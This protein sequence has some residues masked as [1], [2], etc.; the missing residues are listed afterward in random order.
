[1]WLGSASSYKY[2]VNNLF[3]QISTNEFL[4]VEDV[5]NHGYNFATS[6]LIN[7]RTN[8]NSWTPSTNLGDN[9]QWGLDNGW[10]INRERNKTAR[11]TSPS[12]SLDTYRLTISFTHKYNLG[13][14][15]ALVEY[16][17]NGTSWTSLPLHTNSQP[18]ASGW[19]GSS[20]GDV[21][22]VGF[23]DVSP[24]SSSFFLRFSASF[25]DVSLDS[26]VIGWQ[27]YNVSISPYGSVPYSYRIG[28]YPITNAEYCLFL[29]S[30]D[31]QGTNPNNVYDT[32]LGLSS[33]ARGGIDLVTSQNISPIRPYG[34]YY[35][36]RTTSSATLIG[37]M[38]DKPVSYISWLNAARFC[39]WLHNGAR[40]YSRTDSSATAP[41][42]TGA[43]EVGTLTSISAPLQPNPN[44]KFKIP[45]INEWIKAAY[46][47]SDGLSS[48]YWMY[49]TQS[50]IEPSCIPNI[51]VN[52]YPILLPTYLSALFTDVPISELSPEKNVVSL[53]AND[54]I[55]QDNNFM[56]VAS[57]FTLFGLDTVISE[58][59]IWTK[60]NNIL[61]TLACDICIGDRILPVIA[62]FQ[63][64]PSILKVQG[65]S[66][67]ISLIGYVTM[68]QTLSYQWQKKALGDSS[69]SNISGAN[70]NTLNLTGLTIANND[71]DEYRCLLTATGGAND[72]YSN[73]TQLILKTIITITKQPENLTTSDGTVLFSVQASSSP[74][75]ILWYQWEMALPNDPTNFSIISSPQNLNPTLALSGLTYNDNNKIYRC[76][77]VSED[78]L[79]F[80]YSDSATLQIAPATITITSQ[81]PTILKTTSG[82]ASI[83]ISAIT[84]TGPAP[85]RPSAPTN[86][87]AAAG[88]SGSLFVSWITPPSTSTI[89]SYVIEYTPSGG[90]PQTILTNS[91]SNFYYLTGLTNNLQYSIRVR[92]ISFT[93]G[94]W[95]SS[96]SAV[97]NTDW[98]K[99]S[100]LLKFEGS[101]FV[102]SSSYSHSITT[103]G[104]NAALSSTQSKFSGGK[105]VLF[106][107]GNITIP[108][109][110]AFGMGTGDFTIE[111]FAYP[112]STSSWNGIINLGTY[113]DGL[114]FRSGTQ[115]D[116]FYLTNAF[117][118]NWNPNTNMPLNTWTHIAIVRNGSDLRVYTNGNIALSITSTQNLGSSKTVMIGASAHA[119]NEAFLGY[120]DEVRIIK[121]TGIYTGT[122]FVPPSSP[123]LVGYI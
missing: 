70:S 12:I 93:F 35:R 107:G 9:F 69:F 42:N 5:N 100:L 112:T 21:I 56:P 121:G 110:T 16:S 11:I 28:K 52:G 116:N 50:D 29:N 43:Y 23:L 95:S 83:S 8:N 78:G 90:T 104:S 65:S 106:S 13:S 122:S 57:V 49:P 86:V 10:T 85:G 36:V 98:S 7:F 79:G 14:G 20:S 64:P 111:F 62:V 37:N 119:T 41:Q 19:T 44:A 75:S 58:E 72:L 66:A 76:K 26:S 63:Q 84:S 30:I 89:T 47:K 105:S 123:F 34:Y 109:S 17:T 114:L 88:T 60:Q 48:G 1:M 87:T 6:T 22:S 55:L 68:N 81:P 31:P 101:T 103:T 80:I 108:A 15:F 4:P 115:S 67:A 39:N 54:V 91:S 97:P 46:Y 82:S 61:T 73:V 24:I 2:L 51:N 102:D 71:R 77:I 25:P 96:I 40:R 38:G 117:V 92:A 74:E 27:I 18:S 33:N 3:T 118:G 99:V 45:T 53:L 94:D 59:N 120:I 32:N 113:I